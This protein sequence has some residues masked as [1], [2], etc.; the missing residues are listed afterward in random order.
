MVIIDRGRCTLCKACVEIC[1]ASC[2]AVVAN[3]LFLSSTSSC[4][5]CGE[6]IA[7]CPQGALSWNGTATRRIDRRTLPAPESLEELFAARRSVRKFRDSAP[8]A[9]LLDRI[10]ASAGTAPTDIAGLEL[11]LVTD[12]ET[13]RALE[14]L[15]LD[16]VEKKYLHFYSRPWRYE[17]ARKLTPAA[18]D[19][20]RARL[21]HIL[22][23]G[24]L[25][26]GATVLVLAVAD[27]R[28]PAAGASCHGALYNM[29]LMAETLGL[30]TCLSGAAQEALSNLGRVRKI[31]G[32]EKS[33]GVL[34]VLLLGC[35]EVEYPHAAGRDAIAV[36]R[37]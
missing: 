12:P 26:Y 32:I 34:G 11:I 30:G 3:G 5:A 24:S 35:A 9:E 15:A 17:L 33:K 36:R 22:R 8:D 14:S 31:L 10:V 16:R 23:R 28:R 21:R 7:R 6:C 27:P 1:P 4:G 2:L 25:F 13:L 18:S 37:V 29:I 19:F 20:D